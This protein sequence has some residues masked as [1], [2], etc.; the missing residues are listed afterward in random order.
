[1]GALVTEH[2]KRGAHFNT[3]SGKEKEHFY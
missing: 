3:L 2:D 1:M